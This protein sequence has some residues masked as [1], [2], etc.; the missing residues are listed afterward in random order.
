MIAE[1]SRL[2]FAVPEHLASDFF[3]HLQQDGRVHLILKQEAVSEEEEPSPLAALREQLASIIETLEHVPCPECDREDAPCDFSGG[4][5]G[6]C[7]ENFP[8]RNLLS[9]PDLEQGMSQ[10][11]EQL[12]SIIGKRDTLIEEKEYLTRVLLPLH[13]LKMKPPAA[14]LRNS[15]WWLSAELLPVFQHSLE[16]LN[17]H[18]M[19]YSVQD[20]V[21]EGLL[22]INVRVPHTLEPDLAIMMN[23]IGGYVWA[24][25]KDFMGCGCYESMLLMERRLRAID[26]LLENQMKALVRI[27]R[28]WAPRQKALY[29]VI[30]RKVESE[31]AMEQCERIGYA[32][33]VEGWLP[34]RELTD[35]KQS[36]DEHFGCRIDMTSRAPL[37]S[38]YASVPTLLEES[39]TF[40]PFALFLKLVQPPEYGSTDPTGLISVFFPFFAGCIVGDAGY[41]IVM[42]VLM[43]IL[44]AKTEKSVLRD[45]SMIMT[46]VALW[47]IFWGVAF[48][49]VFGDTAHRLFG[50]HPV[51]VER[52]EAVMPVLLF[53]VA[54]GFGH[55]ILG[56]LMGLLQGLKQRS[57]SHVFEKLGNILVILALVIILMSVRSLLPHVAF[58]AGIAGLVIGIVLLAVGGGIGGLI[59]SMSSF[60]HILSY[61][62][63]GAI[64]LSSAILAVAA[65]KFIDVLG[66][67]ILGI[68]IALAIHMLNFVL[69]FAESGLHASRLHYVEFMGTFYSPRGHEYRPFKYRRNFSWKKDL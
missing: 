42:L 55:I 7:G 51:W 5:D 26:L 20:T 15:I 47:S 29:R 59:E 1:M 31:R 64:G 44:R 58:P 8:M 16:K 18:D 14:G 56:L 28:E 10:F 40:S 69:A 39:R 27:R 43:Q 2:S 57:R 46:V 9:L 53:S 52:S 60:G 67:S 11:R 23:R 17:R 63:I 21:K 24:P 50:L 36:L 13:G 35:F 34:V 30:D 54:L 49:E 48:G 66:V 62:R 41:G 4:A 32:Y 37:R 38:E 61:V 25:P 45:V 6:L 19:K 3:A 12:G 33:L 65:S 22:L 68:F